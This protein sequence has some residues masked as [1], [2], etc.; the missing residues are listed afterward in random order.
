MQRRFKMI[1][2]KFWKVSM[3]VGRVTTCRRLGGILLQMLLGV[4]CATLNTLPKIFKGTDFQ[5]HYI[6]GKILPDSSQVLF[7]HF[8]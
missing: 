6:L 7:N 5:N 3:A 8:A 1:T 2:C 4:Y